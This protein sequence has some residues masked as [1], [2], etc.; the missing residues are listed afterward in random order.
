M[1]IY[2]FKALEWILHWYTSATLVI[3]RGNALQKLKTTKNKNPLFKAQLKAN[4][5]LV[6]EEDQRTGDSEG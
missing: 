5:K 2:I 4:W 3:V 6:H 1:T